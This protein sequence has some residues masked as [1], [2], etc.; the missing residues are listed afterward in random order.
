MD[1]KPSLTNC[2]IKDL[3]GEAGQD[4]NTRSGWLYRYELT[5]Y[6]PLMVNG[7]D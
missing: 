2:S 4:E 1:G 7:F 6:A 5:F 3:E